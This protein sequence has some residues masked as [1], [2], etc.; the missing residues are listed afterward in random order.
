M[1]AWILSSPRFD[2]LSQVLVPLSKSPSSLRVKKAVREFNADCSIDL[3]TDSATFTRSDE[4]YYGLRRSPRWSLRNAPGGLMTVGNG[5]G[6]ESNIPDPFIGLIPF[7]ARVE[8][9]SRAASF[10]VV[11][12][13]REGP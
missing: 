13:I 7:S 4:G 3:S 5:K 2:S 6:D 11:P 10:L 12:Q 8:A 9:P 1:A